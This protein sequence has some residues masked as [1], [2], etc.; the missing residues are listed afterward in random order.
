M[1]SGQ[2][3]VNHQEVKDTAGT[4]GD[5]AS[6]A[7]TIQSKITSAQVPGNAWGLVGLITVSAYD[8]LLGA[9]NDHMKNMSSGIQN[10]SDTL[11]SIADNYKQNEEAI[12]DSFKDIE[13]E[14]GDA[15]KPP[16]PSAGGEA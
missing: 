12:N 8:E 9:L 6:D 7:E 14:L 2:V 10:L 1:V 4:A 13:K 16:T 15:P 3:Q 11:K 5:K